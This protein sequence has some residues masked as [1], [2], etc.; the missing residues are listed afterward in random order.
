MDFIILYYCPIVS[1][2]STTSIDVVEL[3][4]TQLSLLFMIAGVTKL[5]YFCD[6]V[7]SL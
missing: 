3:M 2:N 4:L 6:K 1:I 7:K 5:R